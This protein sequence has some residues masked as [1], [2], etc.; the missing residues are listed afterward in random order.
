LKKAID[1]AEGIF[2][3]RGRANHALLAS[4]GLYHLL[5]NTTQDTENAL[6]VDEC[7]H[8]LGLKPGSSDAEVKAAWRRLSARWHP[9]RNDSPHALRKIQRINRALEG[10]R[11]SR[12]G[13]TETDED[14]GASRR[15]VGEHTVSLTLEEVVTGCVREL[16]GE[17]VENCAACDGSGL[18]AKPTA[19]NE[20]DGSGLVR[21]HLWFAW[22]SPMVK[23]SVCQG[24]GTT[25]QGCGACAG[26]GKSPVQR[27]RCRAEIRPG[28]RTGDVLDVAARM[29]G[30]HRRHQRVVRVRLQLRQH[31]LFSV[32]ADGTLKCEVPVDGFAWMANRWVEVPTPRGLQQMKLRRSALSYRIKGAGLPW[33]DAGAAG[34]CII[35]VAPLFPEEFNAVQEA[36]IDRLV[37][38]SSGTK[39]TIA[40][41]R[42]A[43]WNRLVE[44]WE[45]RLATQ[46][47]RRD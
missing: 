9:D 16:R 39:G 37:A 44:S 40:A 43:Q 13:G 47:D 42:I 1:S 15:H 12:S 7:Y 4:T 18:N 11:M 45:G 30:G 6:E 5:R 21:Q 25:R 41:E 38:T 32:E 29:E 8:E 10:I 14:S 35:T 3:L 19:C 34:D 2:P 26:S 22:V 33:Q 23:C 17:V 31:P 20:C 28:A 24:H 46:G 27:Y 36:A